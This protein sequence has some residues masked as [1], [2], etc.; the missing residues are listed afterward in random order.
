MKFSGG[1]IILMILALALIVAMVITLTIGGNYSRHG[2]G[3]QLP[4]QKP[5]AVIVTG[6]EEGYFFGD[7]ISM[8]NRYGTSDFCCRSQTSLIC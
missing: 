8:E 1:A 5:P 7:A 6:G 3:Y 2:Y 4:A